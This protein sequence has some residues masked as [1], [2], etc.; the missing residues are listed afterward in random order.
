MD[1]LIRAYRSEDRQACLDILAENTPEYFV[2]G[3]RDSLDGFL[4]AIPG[5]FFVGEERG[6]IVVCGGWAMDAGDV[7]ILTWGMVHRALHRRGIGRSMLRFRLG[8]IKADGRA[9][10]VRLHTV[11]LVQGF[12]AREGFGV[13]DVMPAGFGPGLDRVT[14]ELRLTTI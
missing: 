14:M 13:V 9:N 5:P 4:A 11:Q 8:S 3:D 12:F 2:P 10:L 6:S 7:A 1:L